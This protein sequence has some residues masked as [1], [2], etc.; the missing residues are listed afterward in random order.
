MRQGFFKKSELLAMGKKPATLTPRCES[1][2]LYKGCL[3]PKMPA[4]GE[5]RLGVLIVAE[6]PGKTED[7]RNTQLIGKS[8]QR[9]RR[10]LNEIGI[11]LDEDCIKTNA[12]ICRPPSNRTPSEDELNYCR[13]HLVETIEKYKPH[14]IVTLGA[15]ALHQVIRPYWKDDFGEFERW[16]GWQIPLQSLNTWICPTWHPSYLERDRN[17]VRDLW[18][19]KHLQAAFDLKDRPWKTV[20]DYKSQV[21]RVNSVVPIIEEMKSYEGIACFD[22]ECNMLKPDSESSVLV[23]CSITWGKGRS[24]R[25]VAYPMTPENTIATRQFLRSPIPKIG[26]NIKFEERWS[27]AKLGTRVRNWVWDTMQCTHVLDN[28]PKITSNDFQTFVRLGF[29]IYSSHISPLLK[30]KG[31]G[32]YTVNQILTEISMPQLLLYNG[33]DTITEFELAIRQ[34]KELGRKPPWKD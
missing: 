33:L 10:T 23:S 2:R 29:P 18:F 19:K 7:E 27:V 31:K 4:T 13:P 28:R 21:E 26:A 6:A 34:M 9:L 5:G 12:I 11:D 22:Y 30:G 16:V 1:C 20:P 24:E 17:E 8:G 14:L 3:S 15:T 25:C 32:G